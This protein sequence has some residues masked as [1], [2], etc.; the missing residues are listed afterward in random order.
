MVKIEIVKDKEGNV[1]TTKEGKELKNYY[2]EEGDEF[3]PQFNKV[4]EKEREVEIVNKDG[5]KELRKLK[6]YSIT[7]LVKDKDGKPVV[8][9]DSDYDS[10]IVKLTPTQAEY[11]DKKTNDD[12]ITQHLFKCYEYENQYG[13]FVGVGLKRDFKSPKKFEDF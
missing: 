10:I 12:N 4:M 6:D 1:Y 2:F 9:E 8:N 5:K 13:T 3:I 11:L 7:A